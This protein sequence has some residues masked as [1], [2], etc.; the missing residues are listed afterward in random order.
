MNELVWL[1]VGLLI[2]GCLGI[3]IHC[4]FLIN[5][6]GYYEQEI[7]KLSAAFA[8]LA[9]E[10]LPE[11]RRARLTI[12][13]NLI[14]RTDAEI[15]AQYKQDAAQLSV[16]EMLYSATLTEDAAQKQEIYAKT[17]Q[18]YPND[19][20]AYNNLA[21]L[22]FKQGDLNAAKNY[23]AKAA[24]INAK[25]AEVNANQALL[26]VAE[27]KMEQAQ[28]YLS[29]ATGAAN[30]NEV[31]GTYNLAKGNFQAAAQNMNQANTNSAALAQILNKNYAAAAKTL[32][33][34][35]DADATTHYLK[36]VVAARANQ[37]N[38]AIG[39][40]KKAFELDPSLKERA[41]KDLE[42]AALF[43]NANFQGLVK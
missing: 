17:A 36:A 43:S 34:V 25:A 28:Q 39:S 5:R 22:A 41:A 3:G 31:L 16:E 40:L 14:G 9:D 32:E 2:G 42:F 20:R 29:R 1:I 19:Y 26:A 35:K 6:T 15:K 38:N 12:N 37:V 24:A 23:L 30:Y 10:I 33:G 27:G 13:Y 18:L 21:T 7:R 8:E 11:L 4:C